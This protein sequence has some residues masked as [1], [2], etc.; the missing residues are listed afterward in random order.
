MTC[1]LTEDYTII[2]I[3]SPLNGLEVFS[4]IILKQIVLGYI[5]VLSGFSFEY[6][7]K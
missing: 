6:T 5:E 2:Q 4:K 3:K 7:L 1:I